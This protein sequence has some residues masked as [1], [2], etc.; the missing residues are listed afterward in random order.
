MERTLLW[1]SLL[2][3]QHITSK[4]ADLGKNADLSLRWANMSEDT[5]SDGAAQSVVG[6]LASA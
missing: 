6:T 2:H 3:V 4:N 5:F 1:C